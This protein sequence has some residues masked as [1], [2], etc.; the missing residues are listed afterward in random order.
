MNPIRSINAT[1]RA[2]SF[3]ILFS[4]YS[5]FTFGQL[6][7]TVR[8]GTITTQNLVSG[9]VATA[10]SSV[11]INTR[12]SSGISI[13]TVGTYT[14][15]LSIQA[16]NDGVNWVTIA[17]GSTL[18][19]LDNGNVTSTIATG[20]QSVFVCYHSGSIKMRVSALSAVTGSVVVTIVTLPTTTT[21]VASLAAGT[22]LTPIPNT[23][24]GFS[25]YH[26]LISAATTNATSVKTS[27][28]VV[29][30]LVLH[31]N[32]A[33]VKYVK[34]FNKASAPT[35]GTDSPI[36]NIAIPANQALS[37][38]LPALA[39]RFSTGIAYAITGGQALL[40]ATAVAAGDVVVNIC[41]L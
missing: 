21:T 5:T 13:Q 19:R 25:S 38:D 32:T 17:T 20:V 41:Y 33:S 15:A 12:G 34:L 6:L 40:D 4:L 24:Q 30:L 37:I 3:V 16:T 2:L 11:E 39:L 1:L 35:M 23:T 8:S 10:A 36:F 7:S 18:L 22:I 28:G 26:T 27:A 14:G 29:G 9:G 31:N